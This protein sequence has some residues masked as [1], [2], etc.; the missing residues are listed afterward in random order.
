MKNSKITII[1]NMIGNKN[2]EIFF[3]VIVLFVVKFIIY[4]RMWFEENV[5]FITALG[6]IVAFIV[7]IYQ[8]TRNVKEDNRRIDDDAVNFIINILKTEEIK[9][10]ED[11][12]VF[13]DISIITKERILNSCEYKLLAEGTKE[14]VKENIEKIIS[15]QCKIVEK[16]VDIY[17]SCYDE[18]LSKYIYGESERLFKELQNKNINITKIRSCDKYIK[19]TE[20]DK[21]IMEFNI[22]QFIEHRGK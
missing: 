18:K 17:N 7:F 14:R 5:G 19:L 9:N 13:D 6:V 3:I 22:I 16:F 4:K 12:F 21:K 20:E 11:S 1:K 8:I 2:I 15:N 10:R